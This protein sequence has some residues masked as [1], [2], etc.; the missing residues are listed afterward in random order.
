MKRRKQ[1][2]VY[3][4]GDNG[5]ITNTN[6]VLSPKTRELLSAINM[7]SELKQMSE[8][9]NSMGSIDDECIMEDDIDESQSEEEGT[10]EPSGEES[11]PESESICDQ[12]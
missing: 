10:I 1:K 2:S 7:V 5:E 4:I 3:V 12:V 11:E 9:L 8:T 6:P